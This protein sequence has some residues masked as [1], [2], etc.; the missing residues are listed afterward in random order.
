MGFD[1]SLQLPEDEKFLGAVV[2]GW[3]KLREPSIPLCIWVGDVRQPS[4]TIPR[5]AVSGRFDRITGMN[6]K[7]IRKKTKSILHRPS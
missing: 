4:V 3:G 1:T 6:S 5:K 7:A 2:A